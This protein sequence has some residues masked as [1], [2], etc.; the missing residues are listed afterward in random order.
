[1]VWIFF[2]LVAVAVVVVTAALVAGRITADPMAEPSHTS[3]AHGLGS[4]ATAA[5][6]DQVRFDTALRGYRMDQ[7]DDV[8]DRLQ[9]QLA[10]LEERVRAV[11][12]PEREPALGSPTRSPVRQPPAATEQD[13]SQRR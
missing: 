2:I 6:V 5:S 3:P 12:S 7:V 8:L 11:E 4:I 9:S 13:E 1:M 10:D